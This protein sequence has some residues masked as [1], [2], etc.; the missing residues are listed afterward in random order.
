[1]D[2]KENESTK[3]DSPSSGTH[4]KIYSRIRKLMPWEPTEVSC[5]RVNRST[6]QNKNGRASSNYTFA[7]VF[8]MKASNEDVY[9]EICEPLVNRC[10]EGYNSVLIAYGQTGSGKTHTLIGKPNQSVTGILQMSLKQL[11]LKSIES[12]SSKMNKKKDSLELLLSAVEAYGTHLGKIELF[13]LFNTTNKDP[14]NWRSKVGITSFDPNKLVSHKVSS[15]K[16]CQTKI[17]EAQ[18]ASHFAPTG[19]NPESSR[20]HTVFV[21]TIKQKIDGKILKNYFVCVDLGMYYVLCMEYG[22]LIITNY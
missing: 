2:S 11:I 15:L 18:Q 17:I 10:L 3:P 1:M 6:V 21:A 20:G 7:K 12:K 4:V 16:E 5:K 22:L 19:K 8:G 14:L 9:K 13:D